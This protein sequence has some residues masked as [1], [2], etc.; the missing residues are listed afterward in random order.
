MDGDDYFKEV[1]G[2]VKAQYN[3]KAVLIGV[4]YTRKNNRT[5][6]F[7]YPADD[8]INKSGGGIKFLKFLTG[9]LVPYIESLGIRSGQKTLLG[10]SLGGYISLY[11][12]FQ[13]EIVNPFNNVIAISPSIFWHDAH[14]FGMEQ[15]YFKNTKELNVNLYMAIGD[16]EGLT[17][18]THFNAF[19]GKVAGRKYNNLVFHY[20]TLKNSSHN[21]SPII[22]FEKGL[23]TIK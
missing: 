6:D 23:L 2:I 5:T 1:A 16:I 20:E 14:L 15:N 22:G 18:N 21:N 4:G 7:T 9:E 10:H 12:R 17:M 11:L 13:K 19:A 8:M 3:D